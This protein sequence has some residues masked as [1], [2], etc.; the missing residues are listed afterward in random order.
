MPL[1]SPLKCEKHP[2]FEGLAYIS[3][4]AKSFYNKLFLLRR[5]LCGVFSRLA[6]IARG[7][8]Q[9]TFWI[10]PKLRGAHDT[11]IP[12]EVLLEMADVT[13]WAARMGVQVGWVDKILDKIASKKEHLEVL[14]IKRLKE[15]IGTI[16]A[17]ERK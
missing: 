1:L 13:A 11:R 4:D 16:S 3:E 9:G 14:N 7:Y 10:C 6:S 8:H 12:S 2:F 15:E 5:H 17:K